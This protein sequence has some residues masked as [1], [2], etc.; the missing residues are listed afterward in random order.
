MTDYGFILFIII[1]YILSIYNKEILQLRN[2]WIYAKKDNE[3]KEY[4]VLHHTLFL[5]IS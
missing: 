4:L 1:K 2:S 5:R 3:A